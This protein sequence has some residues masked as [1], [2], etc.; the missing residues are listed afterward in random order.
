MEFRQ[1][2]AHSFQA[3]LKAWELQAEQA[4]MFPGEQ[5]AKLSQV[6]KTLLSDNKQS[7]HKDLAYAVFHQGCDVA[8]ASCELVLSDRGALSGRWLKMLKV[9]LC[10]EIDAG[11]QEN[12]VEATSLAVSVYRC[13][14]LGSFSER[15]NH[16]ADTLKLYG[17]DH[18]MMQFL[19]T[20]FTS[21]PQ[22]D[23]DLQASKEGRW[24]VIRSK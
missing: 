3:T 15:L 4:G 16:E 20:L 2:D 21:I 11:F 24:L 10:P 22:G 5:A 23:P 13:A 7:Q 8:L 17:R 19:S 12:D 9:V 18:T 1:F 14:V 6:E